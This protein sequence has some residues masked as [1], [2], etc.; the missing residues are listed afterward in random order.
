VGATSEQNDQVQAKKIYPNRLVAATL[1][2]KIGIVQN[3]LKV[4]VSSGELKHTS[5]VP[6]MGGHGPRSRLDFHEHRHNV[7]SSVPSGVPTEDSG[8]SA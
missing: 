7:L 3:F 8:T 2:N 6:K 5:F 4:C 1:P